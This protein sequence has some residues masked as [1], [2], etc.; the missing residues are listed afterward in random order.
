VHIL[1]VRFAHLKFPQLGNAF[2]DRSL[3]GDRLAERLLIGNASDCTK[4]VP[5]RGRG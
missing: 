3:H 1:A 2:S 5:G 4:D